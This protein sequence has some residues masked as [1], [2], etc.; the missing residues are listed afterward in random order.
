M[1]LSRYVRNRDNPPKFRL[2]DRD[3]ELMETI[4]RFRFANF[5]QLL[6]LFKQEPSNG[7]YGF[8]K[9]ALY[10]RLQ[11]LFHNGF[12]KR[13]HYNDRPWGFGLGSPP[14]IYSLDTVGA[15]FVTTDPK[16][17]KEIKNTIKNDD[18]K[19]LTLRH[20]IL[21]SQYRTWLTLAE[22][23]GLFRLITWEQGSH[24]KIDS[25]IN[26]LSVSLIPD[27]FFSI[28]VGEKRYNYFLEVDQSSS[29]IVPS[30]YKGTSILKKVKAYW[31]FRSLVK[32]KSWIFPIKGF[33]VIFL[34]KET[35]TAEHLKYSR[36]KNIINAI[37]EH[38]PEVPKTTNVFRFI[39]ED[40]IDLANPNKFSEKIYAGLYAESE[41]FSIME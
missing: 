2:T 16:E 24:I 23:E 5:E 32:E 9:Q 8:G 26:N 28:Q 4:Y 13:H 7:K 20:D 14:A 11:L 38:C 39:N 22:R 37:L 18:L 31:N 25:T 36:Q 12:L 6:H 27:A 34:T 1:T 35:R 19:A 40:E 21:R 33:R 17:I 3:I 30:S 29:K 41:R 10:R 15:N